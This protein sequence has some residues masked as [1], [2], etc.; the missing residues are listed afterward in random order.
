MLQPM[1]QAKLVKQNGSWA[2]QLVDTV[3][4]DKTAPPSGS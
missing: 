4:A 3:P 2:P 1:F